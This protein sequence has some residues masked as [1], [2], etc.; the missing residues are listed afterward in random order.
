VTLT[1]GR[2]IEWGFEL[3]VSNSALAEIQEVALNLNK[4]D[5][6]MLVKLYI[7][8][9]QYIVGKGLERNIVMFITSDHTED[10]YNT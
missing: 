4:T 5:K 3:T 8:G 9:K 6:E 7:V 2:H 1:V 10:S